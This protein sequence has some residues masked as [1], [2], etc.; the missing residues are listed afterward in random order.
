MKL[1]AIILILF[2]SGFSYGE[3]CITEKQVTAKLNL[4]SKLEPEIV[5]S[6]Q[7][8]YQGKTFTVLGAHFN[9][10]KSDPHHIDLQITILV[11]GDTKTLFGL[12]YYKPN[13]SIVVLTRELVNGKVSKC[14]EQKVIPNNQ[15]E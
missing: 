5:A 12:A 3:Q 6:F 2:F 1:I 14:F 9:K 11:D 13:G 10:S 8:Q 15:P 7:T 4:F